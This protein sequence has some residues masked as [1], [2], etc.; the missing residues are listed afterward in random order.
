LSLGESYVIDVDVNYLTT[1]GKARM[2]L[3]VESLGIKALLNKPDKQSHNP[4]NSLVLD[5]RA[6]FDQDCPT[7]EVAFRWDCP[8]TDDAPCVDTNGNSFLDNSSDSNSVQTIQV[9][10]HRLVAGR[11]YSITVVVYDKNN[12]LRTASRTTEIQVDAIASVAPALEIKD[13]NRRV[14]SQSVVRLETSA[15]I[16][17]STDLNASDSIQYAWSMIEGPSTPVYDTPL[18]RSY[19]S[20]GRN[21]LL[22][23]SN[24]TFKLDIYY[25]GSTVSSEISISVNIGPVDGNFIISPDTGTELDTIYAMTASGWEDGDNQDYPLLY[26]FKYIDINGIEIELQKAMAVETFATRLPHVPTENSANKI[27]LQVYDALETSVTQKYAVIVEKQ[28]EQ[29][30]TTALANMDTIFASNDK[31][32]IPSIINVYANIGLTQVSQI[33]TLLQQYDIW[34]DYQIDYTLTNLNT[35]VSLLET[36]SETSYAS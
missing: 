8:G 5:A 19:L 23:G 18:T 35:T 32:R 36:L 27:I 17:S 14:A 28:T 15:S 1:S 13:I 3:N 31:D 16:T 20:L 7:C 12:L 11:L 10:E 9:T 29:F 22:E 2:E 6:S 33:D 24:Y 4:A 26:S 25:E 21:S 30:H 34:I